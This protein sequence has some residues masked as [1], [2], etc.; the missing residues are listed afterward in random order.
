MTI[1]YVF[2]AYVYFIINGTLPIV[3]KLGVES[4]SGRFAF[5]KYTLHKQEN[6]KKFEVL[7]SSP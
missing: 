7:A 4:G 3:V 6:K 5:A 2:S 1:Q